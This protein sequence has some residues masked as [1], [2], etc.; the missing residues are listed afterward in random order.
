MTDGGANIVAAVKDVVGE[1][2]HL[3]CADHSLSRM[4]TVAIEQSPKFEELLTKIRTIVTY[5][6]RSVNAADTLRAIQ[7]KKGKTEG[8]I[9][10]LK[11]DEPTRW[12]SNFQ[13]LERFI[14]LA[15]DV[16]TVLLRHDSIRMLSGSELSAAIE[17]RYLLHPVSYAITELE[18]EKSSIAGKVIPLLNMM[19][20]VILTG[21]Q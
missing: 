13:L 15:E 7:T 9:L 17:G 11:K 16:G 14:L 10:K 21:V 2:Q 6:K 12:G 4:T 18:T 19:Q 5:F 8:E 1:K 20:Q 3:I